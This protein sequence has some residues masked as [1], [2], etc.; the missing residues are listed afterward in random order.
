MN[1]LEN[2]IRITIPR[3]RLP[4]LAKEL[5]SYNS[6]LSNYGLPELKVFILSDFTKVI[7]GLNI[8]YM[9]LK[10]QNSNSVIPDSVFMP[11]GIIDKGELK[12]VILSGS[13]NN[14]KLASTTEKKCNNCDKEQGKSLLYII[15]DTTG[16]D[17]NYYGTRCL[18]KV[19]GN[20]KSEL[21]IKLFIS[22][23]ETITKY[24]TSKDECFIINNNTVMPLEYFMIKASTLIRKEG[25]KTASINKMNSTGNL[26]IKPTTEFLA[27]KIDL[28]LVESVLNWIDTL[29]MNVDYERKLIQI[30]KIGYVDSSSANIMASAIHTYTKVL[31]SSSS[32]QGTIGKKI[33]IDCLLKSK[34]TYTVNI[35]GSNRLC[36]I[37][38]FIDY[39]GNIY[40]WKTTVNVDVEA[41]DRITVVGFIKA[42]ETIE[43]SKITILQKCL[44]GKL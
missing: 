3:Y 32:Y 27:S 33:E 13:D 41:G 14:Y 35:S 12:S 8:P 31:Q 1:N 29:S 7:K 2:D 4:L 30:K 5:L 16:S 21:I 10:I 37:Y 17:I 25:Y 44:L 22:I 42:H 18:K 11:V 6:R 19:T 38:T 20:D 28:E 40:R 24:L 39:K 23:S 43:G 34:R 9:E 36:H 15:H 26:A